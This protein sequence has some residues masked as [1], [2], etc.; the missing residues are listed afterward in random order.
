M[1][2]LPDNATQHLV[3]AEVNQRTLN[4]KTMG[5]LIHFVHLH[6]Y[7]CKMAVSLQSLQNV[8]EDLFCFQIACVA[9]FMSLRIELLFSFAVS[10]KNLLLKQWLKFNAAE[11]S[12]V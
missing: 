2:N 3:F 4:L 11:K 9:I 1:Q 10:K 8:Q 5:L 7:L 12:A 6:Q